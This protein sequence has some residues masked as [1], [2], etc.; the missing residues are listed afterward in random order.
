MRRACL[1]R[2]MLLLLA[3]LSA[4]FPTQ[5]ARAAEA[6]PSG[7]GSGS[8]QR[9][10]IDSFKKKYWEKGE[11]SGLA[12]V[13]NRLYSKGGRFEAAVFAGSVSTDPFLKVRNLG[14]ILGYFFSEEI[15]VNAIYWKNFVSESSALGTLR[16]QTGLTTNT[17]EP[18]SFY[19]GEITY[20]PI[21]GKLSLSGK[22]IIYYDFHVLLGLGVT[23]TE[24]GSPLTPELGLG[25][26]IYLAKKTTLRVDYRLTYYR[27]DIKEKV[28][29]ARR[30]QVI[31]TRDTF[32]DVITLGL[33]ELF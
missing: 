29:L 26:Q 8:G 15:G 28:S 12:V 30:G 3:A 25:Q 27:E 20:S 9:L 22:F 13:Q 18:A 4:P 11:D 23:N 32:N 24:T 16:E 33:T 21:Y 7:A 1:Y 6:D 10:E 31:G 5:A 2:F 14:G 17:N 19:G